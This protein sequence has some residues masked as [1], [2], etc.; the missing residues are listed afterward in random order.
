MNRE[1]FLAIGKAGGTAF[2]VRAAVE[3]RGR[4]AGVCTATHVMCQRLVN[5]FRLFEGG[6]LTQKFPKG[7]VPSRTGG[8]TMIQRSIL[9]DIEFS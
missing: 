2:P 4:V 6:G 5:Q 7:I 8:F 1:I 3:F 9:E